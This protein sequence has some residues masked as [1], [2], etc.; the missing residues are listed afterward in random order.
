VLAQLL[1]ERDGAEVQDGLEEVAAG[2]VLGAI[3]PEL[4]EGQRA[5]LLDAIFGVL[6]RKG[7]IRAGPLR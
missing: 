5:G 3:A 4:A 7:Q 2:E 6:I 1:P